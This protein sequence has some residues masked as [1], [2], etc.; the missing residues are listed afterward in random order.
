MYKCTE[1]GIMN[2]KE[3]LIFNEILRYQKENNCIPS[4]RYLQNKL[5]FKSVNSITLYIK[6]LE[7]QCFL[8]RNKEGK[9]ILNKNFLKYEYGLKP[10][11]IINM[12]NHHIHLILEKSEKYVGYKIN[13]NYF[14]SIGIFKGDYLI[15]KKSKTI[16]NNDLGLFI[17]DNK[18]RIMRYSYKD[19]FYIL[20]DNEEL[21]LNKVNLIGKVIMVEKKL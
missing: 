9:L 16:K 5:G 15:I 7:K 20:N 19:G 13:N 8:L 12:S 3:E 18:Y 17:I 1:R 21:L 10:I 6:S 14:N 4:Y 11:K 2:S